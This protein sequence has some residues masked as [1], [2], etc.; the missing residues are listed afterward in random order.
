MRPRTRDAAPVA[1][2]APSSRDL[3]PY[4][5]A[6]GE[7]HD[8]DAADCSR[9]PDACRAAAVLLWRLRPGA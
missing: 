9:D 5:A 2:L 3:W 7:E 6:H 8:A 4:V 1:E